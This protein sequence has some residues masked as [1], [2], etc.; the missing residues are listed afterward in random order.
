M[1]DDAAEASDRGSI[2]RGEDQSERMQSCYEVLGTGYGVR[3]GRIPESLGGAAETGNSSHLMIG[4]VKQNTPGIRTCGLWLEL[5]NTV[6]VLLY[7]VSAVAQL[8]CIT[9]AATSSLN[10]HFLRPAGCTSLSTLDLDS[11]ESNN[12]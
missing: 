8:G 1:R 10:R 11:I 4:A 5:H 12:Y 2:V 9:K 6:L 7:T 3:N